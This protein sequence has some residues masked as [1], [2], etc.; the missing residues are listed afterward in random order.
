M[1]A[2]DDASASAAAR[3]PY[4]KGWCSRQ[5]RGAARVTLCVVVALSV[6]DASRARAQERATPIRLLLQEQ[7]V[8]RVVVHD[9][10]FLR[11]VGQTVTGTLVDPVY[12][13]DRIV[14]PKDS[15]VTGHIVALQEPS[16]RLRLLAAIGGDFSPHRHAVAT[17]DSVTLPDGRG[18]TLRASVRSVGPLARRFARQPIDDADQNERSTTRRV[19]QHARDRLQALTDPFTAPGKLTRLKDALLNRLPYHPQFWSSGTVLTGALEAPVD[20]GEVQAV[21][22]AEP[23][24]LPPPGSVLSARLVTGI[25]SAHAVRGTPVAA[26]LTV[27]VFSAEHLLVL[28]EGT[29]LTGEVTYARPARR[30][31]HNGQLRFLIGSVTRP[32]AA[33]SPLQASLRAVDA[34]AAQPLAIDEEGGAAMT[35]SKTRLVAPALGILAL[36]GSIRQHVESADEPTDVG[37]AGLQDNIGAQVGGG[38]LG[39]GLAGAVIGRLSRAAGIGFSAVGAARAVYSSFFA[40]GRDVVFPPN[41]TIEL[42]L[43]PTPAVKRE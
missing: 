1:K 38:F 33:S 2:G 9:R 42:A 14:L 30:F 6:C 10:T 3:T 39:F 31:R 35:N 37:T 26:A 21:H 28:P 43:P 15:Q 8:V 25:D 11:H 18:V 19:R 16:R 20:L 7:R 23:G 4:V 17:L 34:G 13:Y 40:K 12:A 41:T 27:P 24:T 32:S 29:I 22:S 5:Q 36:A